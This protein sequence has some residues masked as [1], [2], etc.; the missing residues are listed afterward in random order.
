[1][2]RELVARIV[3]SALADIDGDMLAAL[4]NEAREAA[5]AQVRAQLT[6][7]MVEEL[8][9]RITAPALPGGHPHDASLEAI[10]PCTYLATRQEPPAPQPPP[11][12]EATEDTLAAEIAA[13]RSQLA[14]NEREL[15]E[16]RGETP[17]PPLYGSPVAD[18]CSPASRAAASTGDAYYVYA[19]I[20]HKVDI[21]DLGVPTVD[22]SHTPE[23]IEHGTL[24]AVVSRVGLEEFGEQSINEHLSDP[25]WLEERVRAHHGLIEALLERGPVVPLRFAT[26]YL[27][28]ERV[29]G[30]LAERNNEWQ[31]L[32]ERVAGHREWGVRVVVERAELRAAL[33]EQNPRLRSLRDQLAT[34]PSG[35]AYMLQKQLDR[36]TDEEFERTGDNCAGQSHT[37]LAALANGA[38]TSPLQVDEQLPRA[39]ILN[40]AYLVADEHTAAFHAELERLSSEYGPLGFHYELTGPWPAYHFIESSAGGA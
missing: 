33:T 12:E 24:C 7:A 35:A 19:I 27:E 30:L 29:A 20:P 2:D 5:L 13:I 8:L 4:V 31:A 37:R 38:I 17:E 15:Q 3:A 6:A 21:A 1:M 32:L 36:A 26:I 40:G 14:A 9:A 18:D 11:D 34:R 16:L 25:S 10:H 22:N 28:A 39:M 23:L